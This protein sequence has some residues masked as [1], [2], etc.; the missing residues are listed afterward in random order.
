MVQVS[1]HYRGDSGRAYVAAKQSDPS[2]RGYQL[3]F[4]YFEPFLSKEL[5]VLDFGC[6]NGGMLRLIRE[7]VRQAEGLE[8]NPHARAIAIEGGLRVYGSI[9]E[10]PDHPTYDLVVTNH[11]LEHVRDVCS[12]LERIRVSMK[13]GGRLI[14]KLPFDDLHDPHQ[15]SW[16]QGDVDFHLHTFSV[17]NFANTL[18][19]SG[20]TVECCE[21]ITSAWHPRLMPLRHVGL[22]RLAF[23]AL[24][25][26]K[27]RRQV[28]A[29]GRVPHPNA[30][31]S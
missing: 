19:E 1:D 2:A 25:V 15:R 4:E 10:L 31:G 20:F 26:L 21:A 11:V 17:R 14:A 18:F 3:N 24:S 12:T 28:F 8:V 6:G 22:E 5:A 9:D 13:P 30:S 27:S 7:R 29:V 23:W 16:S